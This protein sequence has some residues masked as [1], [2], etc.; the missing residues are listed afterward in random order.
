MVTSKKLKHTRKILAVFTHLVM[1]NKRPNKDCNLFLVTILLSDQLSHILHISYNLV[2]G[3]EIVL[4]IVSNNI[5]K[6]TTFVLGGQSF[7]SLMSKSKVQGPEED[8]TKTDKNHL[9]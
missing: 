3:I 4:L 8:P 9:Y 6:H 2:S 1:Y 5:P 7:L